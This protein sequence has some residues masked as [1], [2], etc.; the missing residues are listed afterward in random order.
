MKGEAKSILP[1]RRREHGEKIIR[2]AGRREIANVLWRLA[3]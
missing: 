2:K 3:D 1:Q